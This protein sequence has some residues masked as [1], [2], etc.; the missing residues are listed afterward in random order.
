MAGKIDT[1]KIIRDEL[2]KQIGSSHKEFGRVKQ[3]YQVEIEKQDKIRQKYQE[4]KRAIEYYEKR[5]TDLD[6]RIKHKSALIRE[7]ESRLDELEEVFDQESI[8]GQIQKE[9]KRLDDLESEITRKQQLARQD[10]ERHA[11]CERNKVETNQKIQQLLQVSQERESTLK[12]LRVVVDRLKTANPEQKGQIERCRVQLVQ[13][14]R[15]RMSSICVQLTV[16]IN[17]LKEAKPQLE[18]EIRKRTQQVLDEKKEMCPAYVQIQVEIDKLKT[19]K[20]KLEAEIGHRI[21][22]LLRKK[23]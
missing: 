23:D 3:K 14:L 22:M 21:F 20:S 2:E 11:A 1:L 4:Y 17:S 6:G 13:D 15:E 10:Q 16:K 7:L 9:L 19:E 18:T 12:Q 8:Y 5:D